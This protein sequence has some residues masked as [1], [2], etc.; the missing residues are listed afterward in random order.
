MMPYLLVSDS[1]AAIQF[2]QE[3]F[4]AQT[5]D[6]GA[7]NCCS[8]DNSDQESNTNRLSIC[9][10]LIALG[11]GRHADGETNPGELEGNSTAIRLEFKT[12]QD[13]KAAVIR[14]VMAGA[15]TI[16]HAQ[17]IDGGEIQSVVRDPEGHIWTLAAPS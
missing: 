5:M 6:S 10:G 15:Q 7:L 11:T 2:Y 13:F 16:M 9:G 1:R 12:R 14:C 3:A 4:G 8:T 17:H